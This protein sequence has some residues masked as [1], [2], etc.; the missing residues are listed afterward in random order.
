MFYEQIYLILGVLIEYHVCQIFRRRVPSIP[1]SKWNFLDQYHI[2]VLVIE[3]HSSCKIANNF[4]RISFEYQNDSFEFFLEKKSKITFSRL[5]VEVIQLCLST[6]SGHSLQYHQIVIN[7]CVWDT[8][9]NRLN[10][11]AA[12]N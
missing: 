4:H 6:E 9:M 5:V 10:M 11:C 1:R 2:F 8:T 7:C 3:Y 12:N